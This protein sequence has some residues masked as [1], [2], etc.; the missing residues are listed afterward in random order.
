MGQQ[1]LALLAWGGPP[2]L[3]HGPLALGEH[4]RHLA[5]GP[6]GVALAPDQLA[7]GPH[8]RLALRAPRLA[9]AHEQLAL[10]PARCT[11]SVLSSWAAGS[12]GRRPAGEAHSL[13][14]PLKP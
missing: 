12:S 5:L 1:R 9:L 3:A 14:R 6:P 7:L 11:P 10:G 2:A 13:A 8:R 4:H